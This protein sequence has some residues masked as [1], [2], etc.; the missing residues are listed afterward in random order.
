MTIAENLQRIQTAKTDIKTAIENKGVNVGDITIDGYAAKIDEITVGGSA[1]DANAIKNAEVLTITE[2]GTYYTKYADDVPEFNEP[3]TGDGD[4]YS[5]VHLQK[6]PQCILDYIGDSNTIVELWFRHYGNLSNGVIITRREVQLYWELRVSGET[7]TLS[8]SDDIYQPSRSYQFTL[9]SNVFNKIK[10][11]LK[12]VWLNDELVMTIDEHYSFTTYNWRIGSS[13]TTATGDYGMVK[14]DDNIYVP[15]DRG[16]V[17]LTSGYQSYFT[18]PEYTNYVKI[19]KPII[20]DNLYK[21]VNADFKLSVVE[22][23]IKLCY[24]AGKKIPEC[25]NFDGING[26]ILYKYFYQASI[27]D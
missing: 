24:F 14:I 6:E 7:A 26:N 1:E 13:N 9:P 11:S 17:N 10:F 8:I 19:I 3:Q 18:V 16:F 12:E 2:N 5:Y 25:L 15:N 22:T 4:F 27:D 21:Q 23:G 20:S